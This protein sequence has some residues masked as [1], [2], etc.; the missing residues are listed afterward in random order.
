[1]AQN[2]LTVTQANPTPPT[3]L[4]YGGWTPGTDPAQAV[5][6]DGVSPSVS[7]NEPS[8]SR[9]VFAA[10]TAVAGTAGFVSNDHEGRSTET[11]FTQSYSSSVFTPVPLVMVGAGPAASAATILAGPNANH[12]SSLSPATNP[13]LTSLGTTTSASGASGTY[14]QT[15]TGVGFTPQSKIWVNG[16]AQ[17]TTY[18]SS[19]SLTAPA[20][21]KKT[22]AGTWP[23]VVVTGGVVQTAAQTWTF[24]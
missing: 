6:D 2:P 9:T 15:V 22:S 21:T 12:A 16:V 23:V 3:N 17:A 18:N 19:T 7:L 14:S 4:V 13:T 24:T 5:V 8:L 1:M 10:K 20:V 11:S